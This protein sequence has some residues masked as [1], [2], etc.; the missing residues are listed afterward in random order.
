MIFKVLGRS[1]DPKFRLTSDQV[2][3]FDRVLY[4]MLISKSYQT[5]FLFRKKGQ[6]PLGYNLGSKSKTQDKVLSKTD[7]K[8][9]M[10]CFENSVVKGHLDP[11]D[12][13]GYG[14]LG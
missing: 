11:R 13:K 5:N 8:L 2:A 3:I 1:F 6:R 10:R 12:S 7:R 14:R 9:K 4:F